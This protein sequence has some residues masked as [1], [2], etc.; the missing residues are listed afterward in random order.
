MPQITRLHLVSRKTKRTKQCRS[1]AWSSLAKSRSRNIL[2]LC[3]ISSVICSIEV[4]KIREDTMIYLE[5]QVCFTKLPYPG[6]LWKI[7]VGKGH[8]NIPWW[9]SHLDA[10]WIV[11]SL[12]IS[13]REQ[14]KTDFSCRAGTKHF[15]RTYLQTC[16]DNLSARNPFRVAPTR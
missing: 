2:L 5:H 10:W 4:F 3:S 13:T 11:L 6:W 14:Q 12:R 8:F 15:E 7:S 16:P 1:R 9:V